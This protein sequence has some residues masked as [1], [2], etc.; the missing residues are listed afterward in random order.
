[1]SNIQLY[2]LIAGETGGRQGLGASLAIPCWFDLTP[3][4]GTHIGHMWLKVPLLAK[5]SASVSRLRSIYE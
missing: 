1:M 4:P 2:K 3:L 5:V